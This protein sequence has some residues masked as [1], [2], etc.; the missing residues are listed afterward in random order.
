MQ[1]NSGENLAIIESDPI[2]G[3]YYIVIPE[4]ILNEFEWY[5]GTQ[6]NIETDTKSMI[7]SEID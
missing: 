2:T 4:W 7:I 6:V 1:K 3:N 5:E